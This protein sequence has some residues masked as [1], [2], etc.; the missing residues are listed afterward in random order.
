MT[1][2]ETFILPQQFSSN[3]FLNKKLLLNEI[4]QTF[5]ITLFKKR[6]PPSSSINKSF[7]A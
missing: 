4:I 6:D 3:F 5:N 1:T 7:V 2:P